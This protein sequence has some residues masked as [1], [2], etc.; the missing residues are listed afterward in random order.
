VAGVQWMP[1]PRRYTSHL[2]YCAFY[3]D[4]SCKAC[5]VRCPAGA[6]GP[7]GHDKDKCHEYLFVILAE[8][9]KQPGYIG[10][11]GACGLCQT[12]VPCE[13]QIPDGGGK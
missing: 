12:K 2:E 13:H 4:G 9:V 11:Y 10:S 8:W 7:E 3:R 5:M 1:S 6:I